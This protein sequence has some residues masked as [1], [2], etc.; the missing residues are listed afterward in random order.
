MNQDQEHLKILSIFHY[1]VGGIS[2]MFSFFPI[3]HLG[4]GIFMM[5]SAL[6]SNDP[7]MNGGGP[8]FALFGAMF[9]LIPAAL[10]L[11]G[12]AF[13]AC[14][15]FAGYNLAKKQRYMFC[16]VMAGISCVFTP[17]GTVL[18]VFTI[19]VLCRESVKELFGLG[20]PAETITEEE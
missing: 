19:I 13:S 10:I 3:F 11:A 2:A 9:T 4:M 18:G 15:I 5:A 14:L 17:F 16:L 1:V 7:E 8:M 6:F 20:I 12:L